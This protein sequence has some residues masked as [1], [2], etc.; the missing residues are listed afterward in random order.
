MAAG[1]GALAGK[2]DTRPPES[3]SFI[4]HLLW[5]GRSVSNLMLTSLNL[6]FPGLLG[7]PCMSS[8]TVE[9]LPFVPSPVRFNLQGPAVGLGVSGALGVSP[10]AVLIKRADSGRS[11]EGPIVSY[12]KLVTN[13]PATRI[14]HH[15]CSRD[16]APSPALRD[17]AS[18]SKLRQSNTRDS[19]RRPFPLAP[20]RSR[21]SSTLS[22]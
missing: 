11:I 5:I 3:R 2:K 1:V 10:L 15:V 7:I 21:I 16:I 19:G 18:G 14:N 6:G 22:W 8:L 17:T 4:L 9:T 13:Q 20:C 12:L